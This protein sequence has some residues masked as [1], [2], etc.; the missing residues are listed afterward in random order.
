MVGIRKALYFVRFLCE[1]EVRE[2][3]KIK[4]RTVINYGTKFSFTLV[5]AERNLVGRRTLAG[6]YKFDTLNKRDT[7]EI[8]KLVRN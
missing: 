7:I 6:V 4:E 2:R 8:Q 5:S 3:L 1:H